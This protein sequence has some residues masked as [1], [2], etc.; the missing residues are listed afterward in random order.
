MTV[1]LSNHHPPDRRNKKKIATAYTVH[2][3]EREHIYPT[4]VFLPAPRLPRALRAS[5]CTVNAHSWASCV[6]RWNE[7]RI[8][9]FTCASAVMATYIE[10]DFLF[11]HLCII[12]PLLSHFVVKKEAK[13]PTRVA[14]CR[15]LVSTFASGPSSG[16]CSFS[17]SPL[18]FLATCFSL[19]RIPHHSYSQ[20]SM[21]TQHTTHCNPSH[22]SLFLTPVSSMISSA[23]IS[24][25]GLVSPP[26]S[27]YISFLTRTCSINIFSASL[28]FSFSFSLY[29]RVLLYPFN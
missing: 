23:R 10:D 28:F 2:Q 29:F 16:F 1:L 27:T 20:P 24:S 26:H 12:Q 8:L 5:P 19:S 7:I 22:P 14:P 21:H 4:S 6:S 25:L 13:T 17:S 18:A 15:H 11:I 9:L 3:A